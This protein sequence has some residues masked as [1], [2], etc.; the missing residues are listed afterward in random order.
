MDDT[1]RENQMV[2]N[3]MREFD[4]LGNQNIMGIYGAAHTGLNS[5]DFYKNVPCMATQLKKRYGENI[6]SEDLSDLAR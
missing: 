3:F 4:K 2:L 5:K 1:Y 6:T